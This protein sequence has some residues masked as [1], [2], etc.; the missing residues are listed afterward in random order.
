MS[1]PTDGGPAFPHPEYEELIKNEKGQFTG[2][3]TYHPGSQGMSLRQYYAGL[4]MEGLLAN[5]ASMEFTAGE[6]AGNSRE[7]ADELIAELEE[8]RPE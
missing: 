2:A 1:K 7:Y 8:E 3:L 5:G 4:A 6:I